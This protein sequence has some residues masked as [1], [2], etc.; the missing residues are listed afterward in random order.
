[1]RWDIKLALTAVWAA[2]G[3]CGYLI[4]PESA[5]FLLPLSVLAPIVWYPRKGLA[6]Q[7]WGRS[8]LARILAVASA[9]LLI[10]ATWSTAPSLAYIGVATF[11]V[12]SVVLHVVT[13]TVPFLDREPLRAMSIGFLAGYVISAFVI[14]I[15][16]IFEH[17]LHLHFFA[18]FPTLTPQMSGDRHRIRRSQKSS[19]LVPQQ[20]HRS[21][22]L[23]DLASPADRQHPRVLVARAHWFS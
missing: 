6:A 18:A 21:P 2:A 3:T 9:F 16:I 5:P 12:A 14:C 13:A 15:E 4:V 19:F 11:F 8:V 17:P 7:L 23:S 1:M 20:A 22:C 10:N